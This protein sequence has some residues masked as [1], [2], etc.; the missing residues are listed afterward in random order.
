[1][2]QGPRLHEEDESQKPGDSSAVRAPEAGDSSTSER[3]IPFDAPASDPSDAPTMAQGSSLVVAQ[4]PNRPPRVSRKTSAPPE[5]K[6]QPGMVIANRY[7]ILQVLGAGGMGAVYKAEDIELNR[8]V[9]LKVIRP[10]LVDDPG[11]LHRFKQEI[12]LASKITDRHVVRIFDL[13]DGDGFKFIT[14]EFVEGEDLRSILAQDGKLAVDEAVSVIR[15]VL[16]G[17]EC[18]HRENIIHRDLKPANIMR[19]VQGRVVVMD[20]GVA[21]TLVGDGMTGTGLIVGTMEYMSPEQAQALPL[22]AR[23]DIFSVGLIFY[24][25]LTGKTAY[26]AESAIASL[27]KRTRERAIPISDLDQAIPAVLSK[28]VSKCL[29]LDPQYR[30][31]SSA[32]VLADLERWQNKT[33]IEFPRFRIPRDWATGN[34]KWA[35]LSVV[36]LALALGAFLTRDRWLPRGSAQ[37]KTAIVPDVSLAILPF[38]NASGDATLD[39]LGSSLSDMLS[40][41]IGQS[42]HLRTVSPDQVHQVMADLRMAPGAT[43]DSSALRRLAEYSNAD[44]LIWGQYSRFGTQVR[45]EATIHDLKHDRHVALK[46]EAADEKDIPV[47][48]DKLAEDIRHNLAVSPDVMKELKASSFHPTTKSIDALRQYNEGLESLREGKYLQAQKRLEGATAAD[49]GFALGFSRLAQA[50]SSLGYDDRAEQASRRAMSLTDNLPAAEKYLI[51]A[52]HASIT[53]DFPKAI[54]AYEDLAKAAPD[55]PEVQFALANAY[56]NSGDFVKAGEHYKKV[57]ANNPKDISGL[58]ATGRV[59][60]KSGDSP[61]GLDP[62][63]RALT[64]SVQ[65]D[66]Q[67]QKALILQALGIAYAS[68]NKPDEALRNYEQ[69]LEIKKRLGQKKGEADSLNMIAEVYDVLG[70]PALALTNYNQALQIYR[71]IGDRQDVG[72]ELLNLGH[73]YNDRGKY[74]DALSLLKESLQIQRDI[75]DK[76]SEGLCLTNIGSTYAFKG[77]YNNAR[78]YFEQAL[79]LQEKID[80]PSDIADTLHNLGEVAMKTGQ[81]DQALSRYLRALDLR[82][83]AG[84][85]AGAAKESDSMGILFAYEGRYGAALQ[86][87]KDAMSGFRELQ[88]RSYWMAETVGGY[89]S[90]LAQVGQYD[91]AARNLQEALTLAREL[92]NDSLAAQIMAWQAD[93]LLYQGDSKSAQSLYSRSALAASQSSDRNL[94]LELKLKLAELS[95]EALSRTGISAIQR[96]AD[97][98]GAVGLKYT[99]IEGSLFAIEGLIKTKDYAAAYPALQNILAMSEKLG[100]RLLI[101]RSHLLMGT[102]LRLQGKQADEAP[103]YRQTIQIIQDMQKDAGPKL[104][105]RSDVKA[106]LAEATRWIPQS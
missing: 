70:K 48:V 32:E 97:Q 56:E 13:G 90:A 86:A 64:L 63:N 2:A 44:T 9:A 65:A 45:I 85:K 101:A 96:L 43:V 54:S 68:L 24:E 12:L 30:Y 51:S 36:V 98:A 73:S 40:T 74:D 104:A 84:D 92:K 23:S 8:L 21:R 37:L 7:N 94:Q 6:L 20:F 28:I 38:R 99:S 42:G 87:R 59:A 16:Q 22:D 33:A 103:E 91:E 49:P 62:L 53:K 57:L 75:G 69:S 10:D 77:D 80:V 79:Q 34:W 17:L 71:E 1:M 47:S 14:M 83:Q 5:L 88:D 18:A 76:N 26:P 67:E 61:A 58:L 102:L 93:R 46:I 55:N 52:I 39:W 35:G 72:N 25:M 31:Q 60:I 3:I 95:S 89:G 105:E 82:R 27:V 78:T 19:D 81:Y 4:I 100:A 15:Q 41:D 11:M 106:M 50:Y 29:E 66:N